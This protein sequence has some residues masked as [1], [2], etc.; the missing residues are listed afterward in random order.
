MQIHIKWLGN[1]A[2]S[3]HNA[4]CY[5]KDAEMTV[6]GTLVGLHSFLFLPVSY[7]FHQPSEVWHKRCNGCPIW[8]AGLCVCSFC[9]PSC[10]SVAICPE[11]LCRSFCHAAG[12][13]FVQKQVGLS[14]RIQMFLVANFPRLI[15]ELVNRG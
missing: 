4:Y 2:V 8:Q 6:T 9:S 13:I 12:Y 15:A 1:Q 5:L 3:Q 10:Y 7:F 14:F 11:Y